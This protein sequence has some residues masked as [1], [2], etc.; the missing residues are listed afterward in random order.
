MIAS[1]RRPGATVRLALNGAVRGQRHPLENQALQD[2]EADMPTR[3]QS[4]K[5]PSSN[6][7]PPVATNGG[8]CNRLL[9]ALPTI[10]YERIVELVDLVPLEL[11]HKPGDPVLSRGWI[12]FRPDCPAGR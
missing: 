11:L 3:R 8:N 4:R 7:P 9:A 1:R 5:L 12:L 6:R 2:E 10:D